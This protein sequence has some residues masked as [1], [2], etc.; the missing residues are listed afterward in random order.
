MQSFPLTLTGDENTAQYDRSLE[1]A[2]RWLDKTNGDIL[3]WGRRVRGDA[4]GIVRLI[5]KNRKTGEV[6]VRRV[7]FDKNVQDFDE[8]LASAIAYEA[9]SLTQ[10]ALSEPERIS[11]EN[12]RSLIEKFGRLADIDAPALSAAWRKKMDTERRRLVTEISRLTPSAD[13]RRLLEAEARA[14]LKVLDPQK[15]PTLY[16]E[17]QLRIAMLVRKRTWIDWLQIDVDE[18]YAMLRSA[19]KAFE[20]LGDFSNAAEAA[21]ELA[22][23]RRAEHVD[24]A[25]LEKTSNSEEISELQQAVRFCE[26]SKSER[27]MDRVRAVAVNVGSDAKKIVAPI[28]SPRAAFRFV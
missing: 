21:V 12:L 26:L 1:L 23:L 9:A 8:A 18:A 16:A 25:G 19:I 14:E 2:K 7:D 28:S 10:I 17:T 24:G 3:I 6:E 22:L 5:G 27:Q 15:T 4:I 20:T 13:E 11:I